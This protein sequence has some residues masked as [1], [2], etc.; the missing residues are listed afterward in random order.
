MSALARASAPRP[1]G[2]NRPLPR[3]FLK[4]VG[5]KTQLLTELC[6][7][8]PRHF[9]TY[10]EPFVG[11][12]ALFYRLKPRRAVLSDFNQE[13]IDSYTAVRDRLPE[14]LDLL[15]KHRYE[16]EYFYSVRALDPGDLSPAAAAARTIFLNRTG[17]NGLYR[18]NSKGQ[19][20][21]PFGRYT[22]PT[23][24]DFENLRACSIALQDVTLKAQPFQE[25]LA[26]AGHGDFVYL[27]PPYVPTSKTANFTG[28]VAGG[29]GPEQQGSL[30]QLCVDLHGRGVQFMLSNAGTEESRALYR[31]LPI[32]GLRIETVRAGRAINSRTSRRGKVDEILVRNY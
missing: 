25:A 3:P 6:A 30:A 19:F 26:T 20:N 5:G 8:T 31:D 23:I 21:V 4:W 14:L 16:R 9:G 18:V 22:N 1:R 27:D 32:P 12:G 17:F 7:R 24:C 15:G 11:G 2:N 10:Y 29:F 28:Y 13:L